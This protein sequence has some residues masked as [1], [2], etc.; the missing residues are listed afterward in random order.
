MPEAG[1]RTSSSRGPLRAAFAML[2]LIVLGTLVVSSA[3]SLGGVAPQDLGAAAG[4]TQ[5]LEQVTLR[6]TPTFESGS[7]RLKALTVGAV[8]RGFHAE[9]EVRVT[10]A[11]SQRCEL[12]ATATSASPTLTFDAAA[13]TSACGA[14]PPLAAAQTVAVAVTG[15]DTITTVTDLGD[16]DGSIAGFSGVTAVTAGPVTTTRGSNGRL[17]TVVVDVPTAAPTALTGAPVVVTV[18]T[19]AQRIGTATADP[20]DVTVTALGAGARVR[21]DVSDQAWTVSGAAD[22]GIDVAIS[23]SQQLALGVSQKAGL[24]LA[25]GTIAALSD[26]GNGGNN[27]DGGGN[28]G[29]GNN[30]GGNNGGTGGSSGDGLKPIAMSAGLAYGYTT[31]WTGAQTN[32]LTFCHAFTVTNTTSAT[33]RDWTVQ[34]DTKLAPMWGMNPT[35]PGTVTLSNLATVAYEAGTGYWTVGGSSTWSS[36]IEPRGNRQ[37]QFC[38]TS[39]PTPTPNPSLYTTKVSVVAQGDWH[40]T[41]KV[42]VTSTSTYY[43]PWQAE[44]DL[45]TLVCAASLQNRPLTFS[46]VTT[47]QNGSTYVLRGTPGDTQLVSA[48]KPRTFVFASYSPGPGW[49]LPCGG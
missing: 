9:D 33:I 3:T 19:A 35:T 11:G 48:T 5:Q 31:P 29:G 36:S 26:G 47:T 49:R 32:L 39:V 27:G 40:V 18:G 20:D 45:S 34:F 38:A 1:R 14:L 24:V 12:R 13:L 4:R 7:W 10:L 21:I 28:D 16:L 42:E 6:W 2:T 22:A 37:V 30:G 25:H 15:G 44:V 46:G 23:L 17:S 8:D 43:V 41:F